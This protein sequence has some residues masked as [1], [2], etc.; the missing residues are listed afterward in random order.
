[1]NQKV[2][3]TLRKVQFV[4]DLV[5]LNWKELLW[6]TLTIMRIRNFSRM[7]FFIPVNELKNLL[8]ILMNF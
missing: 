3:K 1:M 7:K 6:V 2:T 8:R 4:Y 5:I